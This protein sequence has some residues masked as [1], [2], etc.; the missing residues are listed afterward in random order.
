MITSGDQY[1]W[2]VSEM[3]FRVKADFS[4]TILGWK[5]GVDISSAIDQLISAYRE[6]LILSNNDLLDKDD[7]WEVGWVEERIRILQ[8]ERDCD[9]FSQTGKT[10]IEEFY[11]AATVLKDLDNLPGEEYYPVVRRIASVAAGAIM[12][13][14]EA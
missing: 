10:L 8:A 9:P 12:M 7:W 11:R 13:E 6:F 1:I 5:P 2:Y 14:A 4:P 3:K